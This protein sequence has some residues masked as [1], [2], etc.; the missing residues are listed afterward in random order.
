MRHPPN[1]IMSISTVSRNG[2]IVNLFITAN[3]H[4]IY[5]TPNMRSPPHGKFS[6]GIT[7][8]I[9]TMLRQYAPLLGI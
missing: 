8:L 6:Y 9:A 4:R 5:Q 1:G 2:I 3:V 7:D